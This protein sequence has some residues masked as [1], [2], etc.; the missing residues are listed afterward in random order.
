MINFKGKESIIIY[1]YTWIGYEM[2]NKNITVFTPTYNRIKYLEKA[3][4][5]LKEQTNQD[6][7]WLIIDDGSTDDTEKLVQLWQKEKKI[8][9]IYRKQKNMGKH[10][11][12]N[13]AIKMCNTNFLI[14]LDSD[15]YFENNMIEYLYKILETYETKNVWGLVGPRKK[16]NQENINNWPSE[17][18]Y[19]K[20]AYLY[21]KYKYRGETYILLNVNLI[22]ENNLE[23]PKFEGEKMVPESV[24]YDVLDTKYDIILCNKPLYVYE[25]LDGGYTKS[26]INYL[27]KN[28]NGMA[29]ANYTR[30]FESKYSYCMKI[31]SFARYNSMRIIFKGKKF[32]KYK[33]KF[34]IKILG[35]I[36]SPIFMLNYIVKQ[37]SK[38]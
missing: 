22:K 34:L 26:G 17:I 10:I 31:L 37:R 8:E 32:K 18:T 23:F 33:G 14:C 19:S 4:A 16:K 6:F 1:Y 20:I 7:L 27:K 25:Y 28:A 2:K 9:I 30:A 12:H 38:I 11:A 3:Y 24:L 29:F 36:L 15:D 35:Y 21:E 5:S 13:N